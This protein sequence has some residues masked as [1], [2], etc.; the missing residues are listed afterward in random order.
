MARYICILA[1]LLVLVSLVQCRARCP[2][3]PEDKCYSLSTLRICAFNIQVFGRAKMS[4]PH[5]VDI[6]VR[7][8]AEFIVINGII[9]RMSFISDYCK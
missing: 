4:K 3:I 2:L 7:V 8:G 9:Q 5:V 6:L 1:G